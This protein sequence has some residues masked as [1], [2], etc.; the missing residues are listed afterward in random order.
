[1]RS[2]VDAFYMSAF[3]DELSWNTGTQLNDKIYSLTKI[4]AISV[5]NRV[6]IP[7]TSNFASCR[8]FW[9]C[10][11]LAEQV[12]E[13]LEIVSSLRAILKKCLQRIFNPKNNIIPERTMQSSTN[14]IT[15]VFKLSWPGEKA[16]LLKCRQ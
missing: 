11:N 3:Y 7:S 15:T 14:H 2:P 13:P 9:Q 5:I 4:W 12:F 1:M 8:T 16:R 10:R 6:L